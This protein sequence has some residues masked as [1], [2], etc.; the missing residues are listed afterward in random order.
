MS[1]EKDTSSRSIFGEFQ[2]SKSH[3]IRPKVN[4]KMQSMALQSVCYVLL[5]TSFGNDKKQA[6]MSFSRS[7]IEVFWYFVAYV[8]KPQQN[9]QKTA[10]LL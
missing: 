2:I 1:G 3:K 5:D 6:K 9:V 4:F 8:I 7:E 10:W